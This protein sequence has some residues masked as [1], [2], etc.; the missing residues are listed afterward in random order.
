MVE[1]VDFIASNLILVFVV[2]G[3]LK[4]KTSYG[5]A[6]KRITYGCSELF[7]AEQFLKQVCQFSLLDK[8]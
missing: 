4:G 3:L 2:S 6:Q 5:G 1:M 8:I 7:N